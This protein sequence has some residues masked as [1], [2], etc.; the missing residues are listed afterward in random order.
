MPSPV[1]PTFQ[2]IDHSGDTRVH[3]YILSVDSRTFPSDNKYGTAPGQ[4]PIGPNHCQLV[5]YS[6][7]L[8]SGSP[9]A[10][11]LASWRRDHPQRSSSPRGPSG[12]IHQTRLV[13][14]SSTPLLA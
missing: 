7:S 9:C 5:E 14:S 6:L 11:R 4:A 2:Y 10:G 1:A 8:A 3:I 12:L 13:E